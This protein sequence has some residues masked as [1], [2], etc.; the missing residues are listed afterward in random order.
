MTSSLELNLRLYLVFGQAALAAASPQ[1]VLSSRGGGGGSVLLGAEGPELPRSWVG[2]GGS[3][4]AQ[5]GAIPDPATGAEEQGEEP[6]PARSQAQPWCLTLTAVF[7]A[8]LFQEYKTLAG[9]DVPHGLGFLC[10]ASGD[11]NINK[12]PDVA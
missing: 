5:P 2:G 7:I 8:F 10:T 4:T 3:R 12:D 1:W 6:L 9:R 11:E